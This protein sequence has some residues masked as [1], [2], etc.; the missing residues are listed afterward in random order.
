M[1]FWQKDL[2]EGFREVSALLDFLNLSHTNL[3]TL[4]QSEFPLRVPLSFAQRMENGNA[5]DPLLLQVLPLEKENQISTG[6]QM[7]AVGDLKAIKQKG[8]IQKYQGRVLVI[9]TGACAVHCRYCF[10][11]HFPYTEQGL[12]TEVKE[13]ILNSL[14]RDP[15]VEEVIFSGG[16]PL[17]LADDKLQ[18]WSSELQKISH[19]QRWRIHTRLASVLPSRLTEKM[20]AIFKGFQRDGRQM[21]F[22]NHIN[23]P[24][25]INE[26]VSEGLRKLRNAG[27][28]VL[29]QSVLLKGINDQVGVLKTLSEKLFSVGVLPYYLHLLDRTQGTQHFEVSEERAH[30]LY[31]ELSSLLP[32]Y[33]VPKLVREIAGEPHKV[34]Y[35]HRSRPRED[36]PPSL[37]D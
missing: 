16:D 6:F 20:I 22:V 4:A 14:T 3:Q 15:S 26:E 13:S 12:S 2:K 11:R 1:E 28:T 7:D 34:I 31:Q 19:I 21:V 17:L 35:G 29:N 18:D 25:E 27:V 24:N 9:I 23:H 33:L 5:T 36:F 10:R 32:G 30:N 37:F 8:L